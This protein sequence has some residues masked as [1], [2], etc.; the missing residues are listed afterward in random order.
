MTRYDEH[1]I[2]RRKYV[3]WAFIGHHGG[4]LDTKDDIDNL[5]I[6]EIVAAQET[7]VVLARMVRIGRRRWTMRQ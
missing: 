3:P 6:Q 1:G 2:E 5:M 4:A 7:T